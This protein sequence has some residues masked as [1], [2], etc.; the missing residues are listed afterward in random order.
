MADIEAVVFDWGGTLTHPIEVIY[1]IDTW[2]KAA[3]HL[4]KDRADELIE[5]L[6]AVEAQ[7]WE[8]SRTS[9]KSA[10]LFRL[11]ASAVEELGLDV[12]ESILE[13]AVLLHLDEL[14]PHIVHDS[15]AAPV[16]RD[17]RATGLKVGLLSNTLWPTS[18]HEAFLDRDGL[19]DLIDCR[20]YT[21]DMDVTKP[22]PEAFLQTLAAL[23]VDDPARAVFVGDR[24]W[25]DIFGAKRAGMRAVHRPN[26]L[27]PDFEVTADATIDSL[28]ALLEVI[29][30]WRAESD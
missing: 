24:P 22:H 19:S 8:L 14:S 29:V 18:F 30:A 23:G 26:R 20:M 2:S 13:E 11:V 16:L 7:L 21:S 25:D 4:D 15:D 9:Q 5:R 3:R 28:P 1:D 27:V 6:G 10:H 17:L 12:A